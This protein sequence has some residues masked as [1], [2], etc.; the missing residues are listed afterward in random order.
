MGFCPSSGFWGDWFSHFIN[1]GKSELF[2]Y[3]SLGKFTF[4]ILI[5]ENIRLLLLLLCVI[6]NILFKK[7]AG[8]LETTKNFANLRNIF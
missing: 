4:L 7:V 5:R 6:L 1:E 3:Q 2:R 8:I